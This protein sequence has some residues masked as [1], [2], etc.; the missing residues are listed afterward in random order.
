MQCIRSISNTNGIPTTLIPLLF[1]IL[2]D[3]IF[4]VHEDINRHKSDAQA[5]STSVLRYNIES[6]EFES[7]QSFDLQ[8]GDFVRINNRSILPADVI[9]LSVAEKSTGIPMDQ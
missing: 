4:A 3:G 1:V 8:V 9:A 5:N 6:Y 7:T 2:V